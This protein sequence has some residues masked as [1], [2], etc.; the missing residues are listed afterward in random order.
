[1]MRSNVLKAAREAEP[2]ATVQQRRPRLDEL[3]PD[4]EDIK[5]RMANDVVACLQST[6]SGVRAKHVHVFCRDTISRVVLV[7][8]GTC[9]ES[10]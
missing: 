8:I 7:F 1:M 10:P 9:S 3:D 5:R 4:A 6:A 2:H